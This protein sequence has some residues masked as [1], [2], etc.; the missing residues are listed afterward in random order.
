M[1]VRSSGLGGGP[2]GVLGSGGRR[3]RRRRTAPCCLHVAAPEP[4]AS[5]SGVCCLPPGGTCLG[6][7]APLPPGHRSPGDPCPSRSGL[8]PPASGMRGCP[9]R[10]VAAYSSESGSGEV[11]GRFGGA[12]SRE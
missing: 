11:L 8:P 4:A 12:D 2:K 10:A 9:W 3:G 6:G 1:R 7:D 5:V